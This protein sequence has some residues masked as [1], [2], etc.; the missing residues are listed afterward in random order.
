[1]WI[2][3]EAHELPVYRQIKSFSNGIFFGL[4]FVLECIYSTS[5]FSNDISSQNKSAFCP[6]DYEETQTPKK[7]KSGSFF[8][9]LGGILRLEKNM[10]SE[11][12]YYDTLFTY[13][14]T[15]GMLQS[16]YVLPSPYVI[17][18]NV[19]SIVFLSFSKI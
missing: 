18:T 10:C 16:S 9:G 4:L 3:I 11:L 17:I 14:F 6:K 5:N 2:W 1:M 19:L 13:S 15:E 7:E 8:K 12:V